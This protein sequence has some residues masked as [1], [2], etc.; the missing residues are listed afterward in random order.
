VFADLVKELG[1]KYKGFKQSEY[2]AKLNDQRYNGGVCFA[3]SIIYLSRYLKNTNTLLT[4]V[5]M[6]SED[7]L[8]EED[9]FKGKTFGQVV[10]DQ[11]CTLIV[12][13]LRNVNKSYVQTFNNSKT[14][15]DQAEVASILSA[16]PAY[17]QALGFL[18]R[19]GLEKIPGKT[20]IAAPFTSICTFVSKQAG[21]HL[22]MLRRHAV[23]V[24]ADPN[25]PKYKFFDPNFGQAIFAKKEDLYSFTSFFL[26]DP[27]VSKVYDLT[28]AKINC[29]SAGLI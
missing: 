2:V 12:R 19:K 20:N 5:F 23:A 27:W 10:T 8:E 7:E 6:K 18:G 17:H 14:V 1:G 16:E 9:L 13:L 3:L 15:S 29:Y 21:R 24:I 28:T 26:N 25:R 11:S 22:I 4:S